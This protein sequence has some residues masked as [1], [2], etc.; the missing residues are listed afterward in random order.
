MLFLR[1]ALFQIWFWFAS[2]VINLAFLPALLLPRRATV[3]G[4]ELWSMATLWGLKTF[5]GLR[6]EV[7]GRE[8]VPKG[9]VILAVKHQTMWETVAMHVLVKDPALVL[10]REL[11]A[12]PFY[13]WYARKMAMIPVNRGAHASAMRR[14]IADAKAALKGDRPL[15][16]FPEGTRRALGAEPDYKPGVAAL[17]TLLDIPCVPVALNSGVFWP[18][19]SFLK[20]PGTIVLEFLDPIAPGLK[21]PEF[22]RE[23]V[24][25]TETASARLVTEGQAEI[26]KTAHETRTISEQNL[27]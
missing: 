16:I 4:A 7:R 19:R 12:V 6:F 26:A 8:R 27:P 24:A 23:L 17:Y 1:S 21:R 25:R 11:L 9:P 10:K 14:L 18:A 22:M 13:G 2:V 15:V 5:A 20:R 3:A